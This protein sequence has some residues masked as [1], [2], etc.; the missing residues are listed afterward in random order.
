ME[1]NNYYEDEISLRE[2]IEVIIGG[3]K[4]ILLATIIFLLIGIV[5][6]FAFS[7]PSYESIV[8]IDVKNS[9]GISI[10]NKSLYNEFNS[11]QIA[12]L[13]TTSTVIEDSIV[14]LNNAYELTASDVKSLLRTSTDENNPS[15]LTVKL[16]TGDVEESQE[17]MSSILVSFDSYMSNKIENNIRTSE[18]LLLLEYSEEKEVLT[19]QIELYQTQLEGIDASGDNN[20]STFE[21]NEDVMYRIDNVNPLWFSLSTDIIDNNIRISTIETLIDRLEKDIEVLKNP[22]LYYEV[23]DFE[24]IEISDNKVMNIIISGILGLM[25]SVFLVLFK[26]YWNNSSL[27]ES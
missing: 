3:K 22:D 14:N 21:N 4:I 20:I 2:I 6:S 17:L 1:N 11:N 10:N 5:Y 18:Q 27:I 9:I 13:L 23:Y 19:S 12:S 24:V 25:I 7:K 16:T 26:S 15:I 8:R